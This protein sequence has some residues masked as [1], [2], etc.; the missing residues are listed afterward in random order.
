M[1]TRQFL[2]KLATSLAKPKGVRVLRRRDVASLLASTPA[3]KIPGCGTG[4]V[5]AKQFAA[6]GANSVMDLRRVEAAELREALGEKLGAKVNTKVTASSASE[7]EY[8]LFFS[9]SDVADSL[10]FSEIWGDVRGVD[11]RR[12]VGQTQELVFQLHCVFPHKEAGL[13]RCFAIPGGVAVYASDA[14][15]RNHRH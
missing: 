8:V 2:A 12:Q 13:A 3:T 9:G 7:P 15:S 5:A 6:W 4:G 1:T 14:S 11:S 10:S